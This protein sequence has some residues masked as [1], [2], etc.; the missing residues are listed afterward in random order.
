MGSEADVFI[1]GG[2]GF[3]MS[4]YGCTEQGVMGG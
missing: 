2:V 1:R 3:F 4:G